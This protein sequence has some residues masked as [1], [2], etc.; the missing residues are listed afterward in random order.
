MR[1]QGCA[2]LDRAK[3]FLDVF[4]TMRSLS[5]KPVVLF[6]SGGFCRTVAYRTID[7]F[8]YSPPEHRERQP[9]GKSET[10]TRFQLKTKVLNS[11]TA[12]PSFLSTL[13]GCWA[14][15]DECA[16]ALDAILGAEQERHRLTLGLDAGLEVGV[17]TGMHQ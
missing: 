8:A 15:R 3:L 10:F 9:N 1:L 17:H 12:L 4:A 16:H 13:E 7:S 5:L 2:Q 14:L 6:M 11:S